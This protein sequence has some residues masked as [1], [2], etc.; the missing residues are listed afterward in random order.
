M[1][2]KKHISKVGN[3]VSKWRNPLL[4]YKKSDEGAAIRADFC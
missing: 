1:F 3:H 4:N 2:R